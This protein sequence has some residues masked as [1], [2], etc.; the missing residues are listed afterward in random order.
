[1][2]ILETPAKNLDALIEEISVLLGSL[3]VQTTELA[4]NP[5]PEFEQAQAM[6][7]QAEELNI[8]VSSFKKKFIIMVAKYYDEKINQTLGKLTEKINTSKPEAYLLMSHADSLL[9]EAKKFGVDM[10]EEHDKFYE[11]ERQAREKIKL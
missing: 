1:M 3:E 2:Q 10:P 5:L 11:L 4:G 8:E 7:K 9:T 6:L